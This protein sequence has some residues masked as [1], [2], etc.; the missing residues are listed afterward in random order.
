M[1][2]TNSI[3]NYSP[4][5]SSS[6][7]REYDDLLRR[8]NIVTEERRHLEAELHDREK[9]LNKLRAVSEKLFREYQQLK[10][11]HEIDSGVMQ[12]YVYTLYCNE[13]VYSQMLPFPLSASLVHTQSTDT[14]SLMLGVCAP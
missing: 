10:N 1:L 2:I 12:K 8:F 14:H 3:S 9:E 6:A 7:K 4:F 13:N 11:Q 5:D